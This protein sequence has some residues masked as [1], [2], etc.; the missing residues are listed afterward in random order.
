MGE[1]AE[2]GL[3]IGSPREARI[4][5]R[6]LPFSY[7][8]APVQTLEI[9]L[10][11]TPLA[12]FEL[13]PGWNEHEVAVPALSWSSGANILA[14]RFSRSTVPAQLDSGSTETR[15]LSAA[16]DYLEVVN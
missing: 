9:W 2:L 5:L 15:N 13:L 8:E 10:N 4:R 7:P 6:A 14:L 16:F 3:P 11:E 12:T 1:Q